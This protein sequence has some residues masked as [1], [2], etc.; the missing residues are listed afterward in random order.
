MSLPALLKTWQFPPAGPNIL[1]TAQADAAATSK[2]VIRAVKDALVSFPSHPWLVRGSSSGTSAGMDSVDRWTSDAALVYIGGTHSWSVLRQP[3]LS[4]IEICLDMGTTSSGTVYVYAS[5]SGGFT[6]GTTSTRPT[7]PDEFRVG[8]NPNAFSWNTNANHQIHAWQSSDG[9]CNRL[10]VWANGTAQ[11]FFLLFDRPRNPP[12]GW[13]NP[14]VYLVQGDGAGYASSNLQVAAAALGKG[15]SV[16]NISLTGENA[17]G[18]SNSLL[19]NVAA[20][21]QNSFDSTWPFYP[22]GIAANSVHPGRHGTLYDLW[23]KHVG[24]N[25]ADTLPNDPALR[26]FA[27]LGTLI[28]PW[29]GDATG[30]LLA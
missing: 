15:T 14:V 16:F 24:I 2:R 29:T 5:P 7:A 4:N 1:V 11:P 26:K 27:A 12:A 22:L 8:A 13:T 6:G 23:W 17:P 25:N 21:G 18:L 9:E 10:D 30:P 28:H 20:P 3:A 19:A